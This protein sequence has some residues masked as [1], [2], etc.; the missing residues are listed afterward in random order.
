MKLIAIIFLFYQ[1]IIL[2]QVYDDSQRPEVC[3]RNIQTCS[4]V[5]SNI[6]SSDTVNTCDPDTFN[7][8]C[9]CGNQ[10]TVSPSNLTFPASF[11][12]CQIKGTNC[13][14]DCGDNNSCAQDCVKKYVCNVDDS[15]KKPNN[16]VASSSTLTTSTSTAKTPS[17]FDSKSVTTKMSVEVI[18]VCV[19]IVLF[20]SN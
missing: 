16:T 20:A 6:G 4:T 13:L 9:I 17:I 12:T 15:T 10:Y 18:L 2:A 14:A 3:E 7:F 11:A 5:C 8:S 19:G 1:Y